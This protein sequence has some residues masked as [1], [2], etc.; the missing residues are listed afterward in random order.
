DQPGLTTRTIERLTTVATGGS[1]GA[2]LEDGTRR[3][4]WGTAVV[5][6]DQL[7]RSA[8]RYDSWHGRSLRQLMDCVISM[9]VAAQHDEGR[10]LDQPSDLEFW[11]RRFDDEQTRPGNL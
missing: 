3:R 9:T 11:R 5:R 2:V 7:A 4:H 6:I 1:G 8:A 10:D